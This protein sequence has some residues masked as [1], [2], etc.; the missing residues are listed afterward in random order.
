MGHNVRND[1]SLSDIIRMGIW[2]LRTKIVDKK[3]RLFRFPIVIRGRKYIDFG[4]SLTTGVG[5]RFDCFAGDR[6]DDVKLSFGRNVQINDYVHI[7]AMDKVTIGDNVLMASHIFISDN[8]HGSYK[9]DDN[10]TSPLIPPTERVYSTAPIEIGHNTWIGEGVI[11]MPGVTIGDG[12]VIGAH[13]VVTKS[14]PS[15]TLAV[16]SPAKP[17]KEFDFERNIW[18]NI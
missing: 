6:P 13:S 1:Y 11:I 17:I 3:V 15:Y 18:R 7:V 2:I 9:G 14:I 4:I 5:C 10:D 16:G 12:C 8:S